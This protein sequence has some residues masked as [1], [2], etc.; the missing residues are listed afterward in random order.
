MNNGNFQ[1]VSELAF[2]GEDTNKKQLMSGVVSCVSG[3][4]NKRS[5]DKV[6]AKLCVVLCLSSFS[7]NF[8]I[9]LKLLIL[10]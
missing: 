2:H 7:F 4:T 6:A 9:F 10:F 5:A 8:G 3:E 1:N